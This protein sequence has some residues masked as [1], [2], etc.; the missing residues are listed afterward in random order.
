MNLDWLTGKK[1]DSKGSPSGGGHT[2][3]HKT[4]VSG[5]Q[6]VGW[7]TDLVLSLAEKMA[8]G[9]PAGIQGSDTI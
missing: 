9:Y 6:G 1:D 2:L 4:S 5:M 7:G 3:G 8:W